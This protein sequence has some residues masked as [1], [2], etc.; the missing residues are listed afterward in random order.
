MIDLI[1]LAQGVSLDPF[2]AVTQNPGIEA[3]KVALATELPGTLFSDLPQIPLENPPLYG[4]WQDIWM[5]QGEAS[6]PALDSPLPTSPSPVPLEVLP[7]ESF[8]EIPESP[9]PSEALEEVPLEEVSLEDLAASGVVEL[10]A[11]RQEYD[12]ARQ[13]VSAKGNV[14]LRFQGGDLTSDRLD[15]NLNT[16]V[17]RAEGNVV[18]NRGRQELRGDR[19]DYNLL[20]ETGQIFQ[21]QGELSSLT[22][23]QDLNF[24]QTPTANVSP[25][26][27][28]EPGTV[29][30][31]R[32][33]GGIEISSG[34]GTAFGNDRSQDSLNNSNNNSTRF[35]VELSTFRQKGVVNHW[36][37]RADQIDLHPGGWIAEAARLTNDPLNPPQFALH[38]R[39]L[40]YQELTPLISEL[41]ADRPRFV[42]EDFL[43]LPTFRNRVL[44][45]RRPK[46]S[47]LFTI[48]FDNDDRGGLYIE[49]AF[50]PISNDR[51]R[52]TLTPQL[53]VQQALFKESGNLLS[54]NSIGFKS[55]FQGN[56]RPGTQFGGALSI[57]R[58]GSNELEEDIRANLRG[59]QGLP[60]R[61]TLNLEYSYRD[62]LFNGSLGLQTVQQ[63]VGAVIQSPPFT[64]GKTGIYADY[65]LGAQWINA[66]TD[67]SDLLDPI[68]DNDR[69]NLGRYQLTA[70]VARGF[71]LW[72][73]KALDSPQALRYSPTPITPNL[74]LWLGSRGTYSLYSNG[75]TQEALT[76]SVN[77]SGEWGHFSRS[78]LDYTRF[79]L[80]YSQSLRQ[81]QSP[82]KFDRFSDGQVLT[83]G[84]MQQLYGPIRLG[85]ETQTNLSSGEDI[86][87]DYRI[88]YS[89]RAFKAELRYN[90]VLGLGAINFRIN[91][92]DWQ[93]SSPD[94]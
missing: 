78:W 67:R 39:R 83:L 61:H 6:T 26:P 58:L 77:L 32:L 13:W 37:F 11:D 44:L 64:L 60:F 24:G 2:V 65:Q 74:S 16:Q 84:F 1:L 38:T 47:G 48:G 75:D 76:G 34:F 79:N 15:F 92:F 91:D 3:P 50:E 46:D 12:R 25:D 10:V 23:D 90:P 7:P 28:P 62:R 5:S 72:Q 4:T 31:I 66:E 45:D 69:I 43:P 9:E 20:Q 21:V 59:S 88:E 53:L 41:R 93:G 80:G 82:F 94:W 55:Y 81:N 19:L 54:P 73:G 85:F 89:R 35:P 8:G 70:S 17:L 71:P 30:D 87:T 63:T 86:S 51:F 56:L 14:Y 27:D 22:S 36:R 40:R 42:F 68:R 18:F 52:L 33:Q 29:R 49:R 57:P